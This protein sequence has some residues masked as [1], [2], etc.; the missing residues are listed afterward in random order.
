MP[1]AVV[2]QLFQRV[3]NDGVPDSGEVIQLF[4][5][6]PEGIGGSGM[7]LNFLVAFVVSRLTSPPPDDVVRMV[8]DIR[9][10]EG[11]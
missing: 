3:G 11:A 9:L 7:V 6:S 10:P 8:E 4:G 1:G 2:V 5:V